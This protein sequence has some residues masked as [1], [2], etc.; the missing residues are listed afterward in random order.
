MGISRSSRHIWI[1][2]SY[3][4]YM[5]GYN[6]PMCQDNQG[7]GRVIDGIDLHAVVRHEL[8]ICMDIST[9]PV[10]SPIEQLLEHATL[11]VLAGVVFQDAS[12]DL[13]YTIPIPVGVKRAI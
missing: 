13:L 4:Y 6:M 2:F 12:A 8:H 1:I 7:I 3:D 10:V 11:K 5:T 9:A